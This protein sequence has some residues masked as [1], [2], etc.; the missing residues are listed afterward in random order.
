MSPELGATLCQISAEIGRQVGVMLDRRGRV[1]F[2]ILGEAAGLFIPD[3]SRHRAGEG[4]LRGLRLIH[5][6]LKNEPLSRD[7][8]TDLALLR[9]DMVAALGVGPDGAPRTIY[10]AHINTGREASPAWVTLDP[11]P[12]ARLETRF[13]EIV[14][15]LEAELGRQGRVARESA[16]ERGIL[17]CVSQLPPREVDARMAEL[18]ELARTEMIEPIDTAIYRGDPHPQSVTGSGRIKELLIRAMSLQ[19]DLLLFDGELTP[20]QQKWISAFTDMKVMD[21]TQLILRIFARRAFSSDGKLRVE[22]ARLR[23][24]LP[25]ISSKDDALSRIRGGIGMR[26]PGETA[27]EVARRTIKDRITHI[28]HRL[29]NLGHGRS[30]RRQSRK[31][32]GVPQVAVIGYTNAGKSTLL[33]ALTG[34]DALVEHK[35]FATLD[36]ASR[37]IRHPRPLNVVLSDTVGFIRDLPE[38]LLDAFRSTLEEL[39]DADLL[40]HLVDVSAPDFEGAIRTVESVLRSLELD[41]I[42]RRLVFNKIDLMDAERAANEAVR[43]GA[44]A[45]SAARGVGLDLLADEIE[46]ALGHITAERSFYSGSGRQRG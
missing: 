43:H 34:S 14:E 36:P 15:G 35:L 8:L 26:G 44:I 46:R 39:A 11:V 6:H 13:L 5:T 4:R 38:D 41:R 1:E 25:R 45:I 2:V 27:M 21:R 18:A 37:R 24:Q 29:E 17:V 3:L 31:R 20:G 16:G 33:N 10:Q 9:L 40:L 30:Q 19:A 22:L 32:S 42:P 12:F 28:R 23:Y 7:D